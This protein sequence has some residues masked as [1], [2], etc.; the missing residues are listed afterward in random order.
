MK[1]K[2]IIFYGVLVIFG[3]LYNAFFVYDMAIKF[4]TM[5]YFFLLFLM[6]VF[7]FPNNSKINKFEKRIENL[8]K[9]IRM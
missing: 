2:F 8:E 5:L 6:T 3:I 9:K 7:I 1:N 4:T